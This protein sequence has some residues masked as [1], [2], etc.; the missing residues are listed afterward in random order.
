LLYNKLSIY[1]IYYRLIVIVI[2]Y[3]ASPLKIR[4]DDDMKPIFIAA[5]AAAVAA[6]PAA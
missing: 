2:K 3:F 1:I 4:L 6:V 5:I